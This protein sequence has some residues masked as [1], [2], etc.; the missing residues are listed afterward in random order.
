MR[1]LRHQPERPREE[2]LNRTGHVTG[3]IIIA[4]A[5]FAATS[6]IAQTPSWTVPPDSARCPS[7]WGAADE[8]GAGNLMGPKT[9]LN[10]VSSSRP[11][12]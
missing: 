5:L 1:R 8:R 9:V 7:K 12:R 3:S 4:A 11:A 6:A 2:A 10:A